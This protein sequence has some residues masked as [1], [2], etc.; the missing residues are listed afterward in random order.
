MIILNIKSILALT[1]I[2]GAL[3]WLCAK[4]I[5]WRLKEYL[6]TLF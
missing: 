2:S 5:K 6:L 1:I 3:T 4:N